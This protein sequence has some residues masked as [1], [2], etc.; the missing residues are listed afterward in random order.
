VSLR[1][2]T[3][4]EATSVGVRCAYTI[5]Q[6]VLRAPGANEEKNEKADAVMAKLTITNVSECKIIPTAMDSSA[7]QPL[8]AIASTN[9]MLGV[10][11]LFEI[12]DPAL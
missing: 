10:C 2:P 9:A 8:E 12:L 1:T 7:A 3:S 5:D 4:P 11:T 6:V